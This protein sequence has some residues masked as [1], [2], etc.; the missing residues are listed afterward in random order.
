MQRSFSGTSFQIWRWSIGTGTR[1]LTLFIWNLVLACCVMSGEIGFVPHC[2]PRRSDSCLRRHHPLQPIIFS[3]KH[4][5][6]LKIV[7]S[8]HIQ[9]RKAQ[10]NIF[11]ELAS[12]K[13]QGA[14][15]AEQQSIAD[16]AGVQS[17]VER[18]PTI[19]NQVSGSLSDS[20]FSAIL[21]CLCCRVI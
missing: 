6:S 5:S 9:K 14:I 18:T 3:E 17:I 7:T 8:Y 16:A 13:V 2:I 4:S 20:E 11:A 1:F 19:I 12:D 15:A 10:L 21:I